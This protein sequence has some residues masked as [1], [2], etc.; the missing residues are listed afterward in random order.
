MTRSIAETTVLQDPYATAGS[1]V[2]GSGVPPRGDAARK[3]LKG[4]CALPI[5]TCEL[6]FP[7]SP[8][9]AAQESDG[10]VQFP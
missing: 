6:L 5:R 7:D 4:W 9:P 2:G 8:S 3:L 10:S 1:R